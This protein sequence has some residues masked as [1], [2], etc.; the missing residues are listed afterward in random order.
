MANE[1]NSFFASIGG[2]TVN[3][4]TNLAR[5]F[6]FALNNN[7]LIPFVLLEQCTFNHIECKQV[8]AIVNS[9]ATRHLKTTRFR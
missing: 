9:M 1:F 2:N 6:S 8:Q 5:K 4:N 3:K 7:P